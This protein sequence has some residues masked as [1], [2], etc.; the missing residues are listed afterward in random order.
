MEEI[1]AT[2]DYSGPLTDK[3]T[4]YACY[5]ASDTQSVAPTWTPGFFLSPILLSFAHAPK[6]EPTSA[7]L[8]L[9]F[10]MRRLRSPFCHHN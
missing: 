10:M 5:L 8:L 9:S 7:V 2:R 4:C 6:E 3:L 1:C